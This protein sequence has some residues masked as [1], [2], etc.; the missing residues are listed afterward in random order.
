MMQEAT[1]LQLAAHMSHKA[2]IAKIEARSIDR[3]PAPVPA[4]APVPE[5][6]IDI[7][8]VED[9]PPLPAPKYPPVEFIIVACSRHFA[10]TVIDIK[11]ARR[12]KYIVRPRQVAMY[13]AK[14]RTLLTLPAIGRRFGGRDHTTVLH[15]VRKIER[16][17]PVDW[18]L[19]HDVAML[20]I[21]IG[22]RA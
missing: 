12:S 21:E 3:R 13:L 11:S 1:P 15:A 2:R 5:P 8:I 6:A 19:A 10:V 18:M 20:E 4:P 16:L 7:A 9:R 14:T 17:I 22:A